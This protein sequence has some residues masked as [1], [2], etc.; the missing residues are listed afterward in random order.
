MDRLPVLV[1]RGI[2]GADVVMTIKNEYRQKTPQL[3]EAEERALPIYVLKANSVPQIQAS[4]TSIFS[5]ELDP[6]EIA[7]DFRRPTRFLD[8][9]GGESLFADPLDIADRYRAMLGELE[10]LNG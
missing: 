8:M 3:R 4:L 7:F 9:E 1:A 2:E 10:D 5:L 6:R